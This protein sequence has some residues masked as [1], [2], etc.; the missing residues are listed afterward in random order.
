MGDFFMPWL[1][2]GPGHK[3]RLFITDPLAY[4]SLEITGI[5]EHHVILSGFTR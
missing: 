4:L 1:I 5:I 2:A 3:K